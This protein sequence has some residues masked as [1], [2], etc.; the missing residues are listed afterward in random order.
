MVA[1]MSARVFLGDA[2]CR[3]PNWVRISTE[4]TKDIIL[5]AWVLRLFPTWSLYIIQYLLPPLWRVKSQIKESRKIIGKVI[6]DY[7]TAKRNGEEPE[8]TIMKYMLD[9]GTEKETDPDSMTRI[10]CFLTSASIHTT[11]SN[12]ASSLFELCTHPEWVEVLRDE[13]QQVIKDHGLPGSQTQEGQG[14]KQWTAK[15]EKMDSF[16][17]EVQRLHPTVYS[18]LPQ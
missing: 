16:I 14:I 11:S 6:E 10:Q 13:I 12:M 7:H 4:L 8:D 9:N 1:R 18:T 5:S 17:L 15:L 3:D 2:A